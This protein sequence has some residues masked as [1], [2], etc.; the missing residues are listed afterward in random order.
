MGRRP[1]PPRPSASGARGPRRLGF[2]S[3][4]L[5]SQRT[6]PVS[7]LRSE[8]GGGPEGPGEGVQL[9]WIFFFRKKIASVV[10]FDADN[11]KT[12]LYIV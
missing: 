8:I 3:S 10:E 9:L 1:S 2:I 11:L 7:C 5:A 12:G 6:G 4:M